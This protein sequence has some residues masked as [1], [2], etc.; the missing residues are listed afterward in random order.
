[1]AVLS[2]PRITSYSG[3]VDGGVIPRRIPSPMADNVII[4]AGAL[5]QVNAAGYATPAGLASAANTSGYV[6]MGRAYRTYDNTV[7]GHTLGGIIA[8]IEQ[9]AF[10]WDNL[11]GDL[12][13]QATVGKTCYAYDDHTVALTNTGGNFASAG[14]VLALLVVPELGPSPQVLV[15]TI[16]GL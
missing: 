2:A 8:E 7:S 3:G 14:K 4:Y 15:Q 11:A 12:V 6:T 10:F 9:G 16:V 5:V 13:V 1:M